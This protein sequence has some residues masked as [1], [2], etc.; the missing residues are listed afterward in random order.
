MIKKK[1]EF[2]DVRVLIVEIGLWI[3]FLAQKLE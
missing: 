1:L 3:Y 2:S